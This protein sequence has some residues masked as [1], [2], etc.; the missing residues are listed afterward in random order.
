M[1]I[2]L[3]SALVFSLLV[4]VFAIQNTEVVVIKFLTWNFSVS[5]VLVILGSAVVGALALF[6]LSLFR[7]VGSWM[8]IRQLNHHKEELEKQMKKMEDRLK[9]YEKEKT[10]IQE[11]KKTNPEDVTIAPQEIIANQEEAVKNL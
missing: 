5:L 11:D 1:Q 10:S 6:F 9:D 3:V 7:Q 4:A 2:Y 8:T